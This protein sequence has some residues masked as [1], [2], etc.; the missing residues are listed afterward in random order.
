MGDVSPMVDIEHRGKICQPHVRP[1]SSPHVKWI[2]Y[3]WY[4]D[5]VTRIQH[6]NSRSRFWCPIVGPSSVYKILDSCTR[7]WY[8]ILTRLTRSHQHAGRTAQR[9]GHADQVTGRPA[10]PPYGGLGV[11]QRCRYSIPSSI[12]LCTACGLSLIHI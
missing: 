6:Q 3:H 1:V 2:L 4:Q 7:F 11:S 12:I 10:V 5:S 9:T 8:A